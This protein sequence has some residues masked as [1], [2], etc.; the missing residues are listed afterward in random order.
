MKSYVI[1]VLSAMVCIST[2]A[3]IVTYSTRCELDG[4]ASHRALAFGVR[5][6][7]APLWLSNQNSSPAESMV[8]VRPQ[9]KAALKDAALQTLR[10]LERGWPKVGGLRLEKLP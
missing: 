3:A 1:I 2:A 6:L 7:S 10:D 4:K 5:R 8:R 9:E